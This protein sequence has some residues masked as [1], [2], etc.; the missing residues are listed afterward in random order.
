MWPSWVMCLC[1]WFQLCLAVTIG[2]WGLTTAGCIPKVGSHFLL[3]CLVIVWARSLGVL[4]VGNLWDV[5]SHCVRSC[6]WCFKLIGPWGIW[7][8]SQISKFQ[9]HFKDKHLKYFMLN[10]YQLNAA[11]PHW[12]LINIGSG[13][14][15]VP[16]GNKPLPDPIL[17]LIP[18]AIWRH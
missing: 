4:N 18:V 10:C 8:Q 9:T 2:W 11:T 17:T 16:S 1:L 5:F 13:N 7:L 12:S 3:L 6:L 15:L 14:G